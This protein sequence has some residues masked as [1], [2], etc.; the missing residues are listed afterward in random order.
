M[1]VL[2]EFIKELQ[3]LLF[4]YNARIEVKN[5]SEHEPLTAL[6]LVVNLD[7]KV[8]QTYCFRSDF[9]PTLSGYDL[10]D[11]ELDKVNR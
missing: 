8:E 9:E 1:D 10:Y 7:A 3:E 4:K 11:V 6:Q 5:T 2:E